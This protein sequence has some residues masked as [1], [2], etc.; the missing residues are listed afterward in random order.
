MT[1]QRLLQIALL[2]LWVQLLVAGQL[3]P[4][5][6][7]TIPLVV[8]LGWKPGIL[9]R[10]QL[11][12]LTA[13]V[14]TAWLV[15]TPLGDRG[16]WLQSLANLLW[17]MA[18][19]KLVL[20]KPA[21]P[22]RMG[23]LV[24]L[25]CIGMAA[26]LNQSLGASLIQGLCALLSVVALLGMESGPQPAGLLLRRT[27]TLVAVLLPFVVAAFVLLPRL[28]SLWTLPGADAGQTGLSDR[29]RPGEIASLVQNRGMA[30][31]VLFPGGAP[32]P[33]E[34][35]Y[36]RVLVHRDFDGAG[37][38]P[39]PP[40]LLAPPIP[41]TGGPVVQQWLVEPM[42]LPWRPWSGSGVPT[43]PSLRLSSAG[44]LWAGK[45]LT[46]RTVFA[47]AN[48]AATSSWQRVPPDAAD[49][50]L[51]KGR[52]PRLERLGETWRAQFRNPAERVERAR[53]LF[54]RGGFSYTL[55][56]GR[57]PNKAP[58]DAFLFEQK[59]GFCEHYA[60]SFAALMRS[61]GIPTRV[62]VGYQG[63]RWQTPLGAPPYLLLEHSDAHAWNDIWLPGRGWVQVDPTSWVV[64]E[65]VRVSMAASLSDR[66]ERQSLGSAPPSWMKR[67]V[68]QWQGLDTRWQLAV[69]QFD[70]SA[71][72]Q[73]LAPLLRGHEQWQGLLAVSTLIGCLAI[74][75]AIVIWSGRRSTGSDPVRLALDR[76]LQTL[77]PIGLTPKPG[78]TL[79]LF[80]ERASETAPSL[81][82]VLQELWLAY[83]TYRY[84][85]STQPETSTESQK[86]RR[87][88]NQA[89]K[90]LNRELQRSHQRTLADRP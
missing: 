40:A 74:A 42:P 37:W 26:A 86:M 32:P 19:L 1:N 4:L 10:T 9:S 31:R 88:I 14:V 22:P 76:C 47:V 79:Q 3:L 59:E 85:S 70:S 23:A 35:R 75:L 65:R 64:P 44:T 49:L 89:R 66:A 18:G 81:A 36:W 38:S 39:G 61:A 71:Q 12:L 50:A 25:L 77:R 72:A 8:L 58:L 34:A 16:S 20:P 68:D 52:N 62:V 69:M 28:P 15:T 67:L 30:A 90:R 17:L 6:I 21:T 5:A 11:N 55:E 48:E 13:G 54:S 7:G 82:P 29:L 56:P 84:E 80:C 83:D 60:A 2:I 46:E 41:A 43:D 53:E 57:L 63:G 73:L 87:T 51:P 27:A 24:M 78:E 33:P 45:P